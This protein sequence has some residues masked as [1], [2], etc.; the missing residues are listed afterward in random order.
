VT[1]TE[2]FILGLMAAWTPG[3]IILAWLLRHSIVDEEPFE[4]TRTLGESTDET[5]QTAASPSRS[6]SAAIGIQPAVEPLPG[7]DPRTTQKD[8]RTACRA[9]LIV[10]Q[11]DHATLGAVVEAEFLEPVD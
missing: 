10:A 9:E 4:Q 5:T 7:C 6:R 8:Q 3:L 11:L 1:N 2:A